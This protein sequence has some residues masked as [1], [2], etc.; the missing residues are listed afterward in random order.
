MGKASRN[1][2]ERKLEREAKSGAAAAVKEKGQSKQTGI[3]TIED[4]LKSAANSAATGN[5]FIFAGNGLLS[6]EAARKVYWTDV[7]ES[8]RMRGA[9]CL[10]D[11]A[12]LGHLMGQSLLDVK[13]SVL[14]KATGR[15]RLE[16]IFSAMFLFGD[17]D[18]FLFLLDEAGRG[19]CNWEMLGQVFRSVVHLASALEEE[20]AHMVMAKALV[21]FMAETFH[22]EGCLAKAM[23]DGK[24]VMGQPFAR[25]IAQDY[26]DELEA[27][28]ERAELE[29]V[30]DQAI[31]SAAANVVRI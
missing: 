2:W 18:A 16:D 31:R 29:E 21:R 11:M 14:D 13:I 9:S 7:G 20:S 8:Y 6:P 5:H 24:S 12:A 15:E 26:L 4:V 19:G 23:S 3:L 27:D 28:R 10:P 17:L 22:K 1:K 25:R 30:A